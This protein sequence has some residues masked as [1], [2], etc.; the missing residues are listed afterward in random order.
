MLAILLSEKMDPF[1][2]NISS[3]PTIF[4]SITLVFSMMFWCVSVLGLVDIDFIDIPLI[5]L[6]SR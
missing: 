5:T 6:I 3:F 4:F 2:L 1:Y